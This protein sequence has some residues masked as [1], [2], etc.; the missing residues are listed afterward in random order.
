MNAPKFAVESYGAPGCFVM[1]N[2]RRFD[3]LDEAIDDACGRV[4]L[5]R[6]R[7]PWVWADPNER[8]RSIDGTT[9][10]W[11]LVFGIHACPDCHRRGQDRGGVRV[12]QRL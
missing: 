5:N 6:L 12:Y 11:K 1:P 10:E 8:P 3:R 2:I 4:N 9:D 7:R